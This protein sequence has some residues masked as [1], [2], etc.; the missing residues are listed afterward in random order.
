MKSRGGELVEAELA[1]HAQDDAG[2]VWNLGEYPEEYED[3]EFLGAPSTWIFGIGSVE[4]GILVLGSPRVGDRF[5]QG[6]GLSPR[7]S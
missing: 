6:A 5:L 4:G 2:G 7:G 1:F 3:G